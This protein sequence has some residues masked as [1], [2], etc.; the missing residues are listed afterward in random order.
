MIDEA[1]EMVERESGTHTADREYRFE[2][3][4]SGI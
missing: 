3:S 2:P 4:I 1:V